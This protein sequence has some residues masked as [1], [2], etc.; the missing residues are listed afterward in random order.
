MIGGAGRSAASPP[1]ELCRAQ[2]VGR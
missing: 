2:G 1:L